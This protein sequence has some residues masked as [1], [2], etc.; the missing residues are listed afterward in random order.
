MTNERRYD[1]GMSWD[2]MIKAIKEIKNEWGTKIEISTEL[3]YWYYDDVSP[4]LVITYNE[5]KNISWK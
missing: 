2:E 1:F 4:V 3:E 5:W